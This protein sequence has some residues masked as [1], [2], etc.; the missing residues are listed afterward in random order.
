M[1]WIIRNTSK[2]KYHTNLTELFRPIIGYIG[3]YKWLISDLEF[4]SDEPLSF[5]SMDKDYNLLTSEQFRE[6][7]NHDM[8]FIWA[9]IIAIPGSKNKPINI[10][11]LPFVEGNE[12]IWKN[13]NIQYPEGEI[14]V[15]CFDIDGRKTK[16]LFLGKAANN[17]NYRIYQ[18]LLG[19]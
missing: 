7:L 1:N 18:E 5:L 15:D 14:E 11:N 17:E 9:A 10:D 3:D 4:T 13:D 6:L 16:Q 12:L 8:Q 19:E 2:L